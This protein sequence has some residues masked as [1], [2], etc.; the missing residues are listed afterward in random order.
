VRLNALLEIVVVANNATQLAK[1]PAVEQTKVK[2]LLGNI[3][4][5]LTTLE[6]NTTLVK[7]CQTERDCK[8]LL[9]LEKW[10]TIL[11]NTTAVTAIQSALAAKDHLSQNLTVVEVNAFKTNVTSR[12][13]V[14]M[15][16][17]TLVAECKGA[18]LGGTSSVIGIVATKT[19]SGAASATGTV[20]KATTN[21]AVRSMEAV[22]SGGAFAMAFFFASFLF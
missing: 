8:E 7:F 16:N 5:E 2:G 17:A 13:N 19:T 4:A 3:T 6:A 18:M 22:G 21:A 1:L 20:V 9:Q 15:S 12:L 10:S 11:S 14:L